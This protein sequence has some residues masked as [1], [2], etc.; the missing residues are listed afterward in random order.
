MGTPAQQ[1]P[2]R[3]VL[4]DL[5]DT[6]CRI[7]ESSYMSGKRREADLL[8]V[9]P[10]RFMEAWHGTGDRAQTGALPDIA[11]RARAAAEMVG[12]SPDMETL[13]E[14]LR[15]EEATMTGAA[16]LYPDVLP[17]LNDL[18]GRAGLK[19]GLVSNASSIAAL[20]LDSLEIGAYFDHVTFSFRVG[21]VKPD[22][23]IYLSAA[24]AIDVRPDACLF[25]GDGNGRELNG[26]RGVG[27]EAVRIERPITPGP[28][29]KSESTEFD[30]SIRTLTLIPSLLRV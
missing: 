27:M 10:D 12:V 20:L 18:R 14:I 3:A 2:H 6:L 25:V 7:D 19:V 15:I 24:D 21:L 23:A 11:A 17:T 22:P 16:S 8:G 29:R 5:F 30:H 4:F 13:R 28:Y 1:G 9:D 26:A